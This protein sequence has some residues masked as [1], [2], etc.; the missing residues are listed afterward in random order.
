MWLS[1]LRDTEPP[2]HP[3][4]RRRRPAGARSLL[5]PTVLRRRRRPTSPS[6]TV[7][8]AMDVVVVGFAE[9][10]GAP[11]R[12]SRAGGLRRGQP[13]RG[14]RLRRPPA[15]GHAGRPLRRLRRLSS[16]CAA[17]LLLVVDSLA[18]LVA[19]GFLA[20]L[21]IA[22]VLVSGMSLVE[23]RVP[24]S[25]LT[26]SLTWV[27]T[28][29]TLGVTVGLGR[30]RGRRRRLGRRDRLRRPRTLGRPG[31]RAGPRRRPPATAQC[32][33]GGPRGCSSDHGAVTTVE[34]TWVVTG[35]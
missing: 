2:V 10:E 25:A 14:A 1:R 5:N 18:S 29:L 13:G 26:E 17:Q 3:R 8:G 11:V 12:R 35:P 33:G 23:S 31:R 4:R 15:A 16:A 21:A 6:A 34:A 27:V 19:V 30:R 32:A 28:G 22:P 9:A 7:F 20:G 24:R